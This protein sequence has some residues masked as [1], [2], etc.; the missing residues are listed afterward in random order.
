MSQITQNMKE[1]Q[2]MT[3]LV[4]AN[5]GGAANDSPT[6]IATSVNNIK[7][8]PKNIPSDRYANLYHRKIQYGIFDT[9]P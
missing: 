9:A 4:I 6:S 2:D 5:M 1:L 8:D 3:K 7:V